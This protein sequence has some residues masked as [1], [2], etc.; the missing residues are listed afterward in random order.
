MQLSV[1]LAIFPLK[2]VFQSL[3]NFSVYIRDI[4]ILI[5][6]SKVIMSSLDINV[7]IYHDENDMHSCP[8]SYVDS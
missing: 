5:T 8:K 2:N 3:V 6:T 1:S 4:K 7:N